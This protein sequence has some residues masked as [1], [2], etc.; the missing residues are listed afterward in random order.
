VTPD[1]P[2]GFASLVYVDLDAMPLAHE[3]KPV[4]KTLAIP[5]WLNVAA[6]RKK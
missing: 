5:S 4:K 1:G 3:E 2:S 6:E